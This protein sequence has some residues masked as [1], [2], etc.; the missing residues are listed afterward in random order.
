MPVELTT[1]QVRGFTRCQMEIEEGGVIFLVEIMAATV[2]GGRF[3]FHKEFVARHCPDRAGKKYVQVDKTWT[4]FDLA[5]FSV[6]PPR[7]H[8]EQFRMRNETYEIRIRGFNFPL[9]DWMTDL[10]IPGV[11]EKD[12]ARA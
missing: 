2:L 7:D 9:I 6:L 12:L 10:D 1:E 11:H 4:S 8:R 3:R 5:S